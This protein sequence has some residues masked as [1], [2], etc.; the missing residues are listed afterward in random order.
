[1]D[2]STQREIRLQQLARTL[3]SGEMT[4]E[5]RQEYDTLQNEQ[6]D[7]LKGAMLNIVEKQ[8]KPR[9]PKFWCRKS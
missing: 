1:M 6:S 7:E 3:T 5:E 8:V 9:L 4:E 2:K